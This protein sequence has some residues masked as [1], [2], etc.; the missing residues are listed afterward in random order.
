M[1][2]ASQDFGCGGRQHFPPAIWFTCDRMVT[3]QR[4]EG[5]DTL[6]FAGDFDA[7]YCYNRWRVGPSKHS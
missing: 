1:F 3:E 5:F 4:C 6:V 7:G 2:Q